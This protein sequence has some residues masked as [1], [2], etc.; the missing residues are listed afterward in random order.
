MKSLTMSALTKIES[1]VKGQYLDFITGLLE[2][3][4]AGGY[5]ILHNL[6]GKGTHGA[7]KGH[8]MFNDESVLVMVISAAPPSLTDAILEGATPFLD[9]RMGVVFTSDIAVSRMVRPGP[10]D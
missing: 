6:S 10:D 8:L 9:R 5:S 4:G 3:A 1:I 7:H 2:R